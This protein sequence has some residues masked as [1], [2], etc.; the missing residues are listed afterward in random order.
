VTRVARD[1]LIILN[2][3]ADRGRA[4]RLAPRLERAMQAAGARFE[5]VR[6]TRRREAEEMAESAAR[7]G[8]GAVIAV[9]GDGVVHEVAN[10]LMRAAGDGPTVPLGVVPAGTGNDF[11]KMLGL[12]PRRPDQALR[13]ILA[14]EPR[15]VDIGEVFAADMVEGPEEPWYFTNGIGLGFDAQVA[16]HASRVMRLRGM[17]VYAV[18]L[19]RTL[20]DLRNPH[21]TISV[22]GEEVA[23]RA[24]ILATVA[25]GPCHGGS[26]WL[27]PDAR[28][29][30]GVFD[31]L[32]AD[33]RTVREVL[34]L[35]PSV[36]RGR[37]LNARG[38]RVLRGTRVSVRSTELLPIHADGEIV[39]RGVRSMEIRMLPGRLR[40]LA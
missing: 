31:V 14:A 24:L 10:G 20:R 2:P 23:D 28:V 29:D 38:V 34:P 9:G 35:I 7:A 22:D 25:N 6:T 27:A 16:V 12:S 39:A 30:D 11:V 19:V 17:L 37:H 4:D 32:V 8:R 18:A 3:A 13:R 33:A 21:F 36:M 26:F 5:L 40:V 15:P 1:Y